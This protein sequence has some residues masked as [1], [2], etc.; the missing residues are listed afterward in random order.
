MKAKHWIAIGAATGLAAGS[1][2]ALYRRSQRKLKKLLPSSTEQ[3]RRL[4]ERAA[5]LVRLPTSRDRMPEV[6]SDGGGLRCPQTGRVYP[7]RD[8]VLHLLEDELDLTTT[9][10]ML[11]TPFTAWVYD[12]YR[13]ALLYMFNLPDFSEEVAAIQSRLQVRPG[14]KVLDLA[15]GQGNFTV[16]WAKRAGPEGLVI[17]LDISKAMLTRAAYHV[18]Q[19]GLDNVLLVRGNA[20]GMPF[21]DGSFSKVNCSGGFHQFPDLSQALGEIARVSASWAVLTASTFAEAPDDRHADLKRWLKRRYDFH[22]VPIVWMGEELAQ[23]GY[24]SYDWTLPGGWF[25]YTSARKVSD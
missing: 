16:E 9:Q 19:W 6:L 2:V 13:S 8:G 18:S 1:A 22:F 7:Y 17:G 20:L 4:L 5:H 15:C 3:K 23:S 21:A 11:N 24:R 25:A 12:R 14:D 10:K